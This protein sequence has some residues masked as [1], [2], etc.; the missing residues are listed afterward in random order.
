[1]APSALPQPRGSYGTASMSSSRTHSLGTATCRAEGTSACEPGSPL[2]VPKPCPDAPNAHLCGPTCAPGEENHVCTGRSRLRPFGNCI[3]LEADGEPATCMLVVR[4]QAPSVGWATWPV[5]PEAQPVAH[6]YDRCV[7]VHQCPVG[8]QGPGG[9]KA[10]A[11][12]SSDSE[13][14]RNVGHSGDSFARNAPLHRIDCSRGPVPKALPI[15]DTGD[16]TTA[17]QIRAKWTTR[18]RGRTP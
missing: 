11:Q 4:N 14:L 7:P 6:E 2:P 5:E 13:A 1:M 3:L 17:E 15:G 10:G 18:G 12:Q 9:T 8:Q 16:K